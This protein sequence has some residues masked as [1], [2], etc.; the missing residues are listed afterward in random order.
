[1]SPTP[2][3]SGLIPIYENAPGP[4]PRGTRSFPGHVRRLPGDPMWLAATSTFIS[5]WLPRSVLADPRGMM[6]E[7]SHEKSFPKR[8]GPLETSEN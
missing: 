5:A 2:R 6:L 1:M 7:V 4:R 3:K 8:L